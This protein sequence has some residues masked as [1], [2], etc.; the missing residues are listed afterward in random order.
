MRATIEWSH[1]LLTTEA[2]V[3]LRRL[4]VLRGRFELGTVAAV[5][6][7]EP[8][9]EVDVLSLVEE[10]VETSFV[11][12]ENDR[13]GGLSM[14][15]TIREFARQQLDESGEADVIRSRHAAH[16]AERAGTRPRFGS[17]DELQHLR[18]LSAAG[19]D[20]RA[21]LDWSLRHG[22]TDLAT[23]L[24]AGLALRWYTEAGADEALRW[25]VEGDQGVA[26]VERAEALC[27]LG[28]SLPWMGRGDEALLAADELTRIA[29]RIGL[30]ELQA[31]ALWVR[32]SI[33]TAAGDIAE[34]TRCFDRGASILRIADH[35][36]LSVFLFD[37]GT[38]KLWLGNREQAAIVVDEL[39]EVAQRWDQP[40]S[41]IRVRLLR[42]LTAYMD[43]DVN[44]ALN[45]LTRSLAEMRA[46]GLVGPQIDPLRCVCDAADA[47][48]A[49]GVAERAAN[50]L[51]A[52]LTESGEVVALPVAY[53][54]LASVA[55]ARG[56]L[57]GASRAVERGL[58]VIRQTGASFALD[59][60]LLAAARVARALGRTSQAAGLHSARVRRGLERGVVDCCPGGPPRHPGD[61]V[62]R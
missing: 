51:T 8:I 1:G 38:R 26:S 33:A 46:L 42:G 23:Q 48:E 60:A 61:A 18:R 3:M 15:E 57:D 34:S 24:A 62:A 4:S 25:L 17:S 35:P 54:T 28:L 44:R 11:V 37:L 16:F 32:A 10:L 36:Q 49:W 7:H 13:T 53:D 21:A 30:P 27:G 31:D 22:R 2:Q 56:D 39:A 40:L 19:N 58:A 43:G 52:L 29:D 45:G 12:R 55:L 9:G 14:L 20:I 47:A 50:E 5:C 41:M 59:H 6:S